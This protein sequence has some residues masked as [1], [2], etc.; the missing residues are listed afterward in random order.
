MHTNKELD[1]WISLVSVQDIDSVVDLYEEEGLLLG[2]FSDEIRMGKEKIREYFKYFLAQKP[3]ASVVDSVT[4]MI[5]DDILVANGFYDFEVLDDIQDTKIVH[6]R[7]TFVFK[8]KA[9]SFTILSHHSSV[10]P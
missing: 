10:M 3:K 9:D 1:K 4:H 5:G 8:L 7:F 2:T 6:A